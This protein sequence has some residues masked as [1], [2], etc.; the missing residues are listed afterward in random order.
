MLKKEDEYSFSGADEYSWKK[1]GLKY[2]EV[3]DE[4]V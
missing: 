1:R 4:I 2:M 3:I